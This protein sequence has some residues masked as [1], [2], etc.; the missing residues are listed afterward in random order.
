M[1]NYV[2]QKLITSHNLIPDNVPML[3]TRGGRDFLKGWKVQQYMSGLKYEDMPYQ[4]QSQY[5]NIYHLHTNIMFECIYDRNTSFYSNEEG[6]NFSKA[7]QFN[8]KDVKD[9]LRSFSKEVSQASKFYIDLRGP[10]QLEQKEIDKIQSELRV[11]SPYK[12]VFLQV[13]TEYQVHNILIY[14]SGLHVEDKL[15]V[16]SFLSFINMPYYK[17][18]KGQT[19]KSNYFNFDPN[20]Y[21]IVFHPN[22]GGYTYEINGQGMVDLDG[23]R[24]TLRNKFHNFLDLQKEIDGSYKNEGLEDHVTTIYTIF[25]HFMILLQYPMICAQQEVKGRG[26]VFLDRTVTHKHTELMRQPKF[27]HKVLKLDLYGNHNEAGGFVE[28]G[29][30]VALHSVR[31]HLRRL[32]NGKL[33]FVKA[34]FR[35]TKD[36]GMVIK[37]YEMDP[38][39]PIQDGGP[40]LH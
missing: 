33:T 17:R 16:E 31:K 38:T 6:V 23:E 5:E 2:L 39:I 25:M 11:Y 3:D 14:D 4:V 26:N 40:N 19:G 15:G 8:R 18:S 24:M 7:H 13:E 30:G 34:H 20:I 12:S 21:N 10:D 1:N 36:K 27:T 37:D 35:G 32:K 22:Q 9:Y 29:K 28:R